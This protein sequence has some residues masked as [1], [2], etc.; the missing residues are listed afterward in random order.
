MKEYS[1]YDTNVKGQLI[2]DLRRTKDSNT[3]YVSHYFFALNDGK[4]LIF[5]YNPQHYWD[6]VSI[7]QLEESVLEN[8]KQECAVFEDFDSDRET[9]H[10]A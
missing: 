10:D 9:K 7:D 6:K 5:Y 1:G 2:D 4:H 3:L 8:L